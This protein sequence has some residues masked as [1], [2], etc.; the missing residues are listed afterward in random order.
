M[1][2]SAARPSPRSTASGQAM[3][4]L[5]IRDAEL[6]G[7]L[8]PDQAVARERHHLIE[9]GQ[10]V[11]HAAG[12]LARNDRERLVVGLDLL[13]ARSGARARRS[14]LRDQPKS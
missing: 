6:L 13:V 2:S 12:C 10:R 1:T 11:A 3:E 8:A 5:T 14:C 7:H 4:V 9:Q